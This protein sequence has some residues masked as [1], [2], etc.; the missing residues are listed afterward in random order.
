M[1]SAFPII[2]EYLITIAV[3]KWNHEWMMWSN[4]YT[5]DVKWL[6][7]LKAKRN[8][9]FWLF[10]DIFILRFKKGYIMTWFFDDFT[11]GR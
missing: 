10:Y 11:E 3:M 8:N 5:Y 2:V 1:F 4:K 9:N 6:L 7:E